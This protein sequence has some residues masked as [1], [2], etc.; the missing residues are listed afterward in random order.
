MTS[1]CDHMANKSTWRVDPARFARLGGLATLRSLG[2]ARVT[3]R[4]SPSPDHVEGGRTVGVNRVFACPR[5][6]SL[7]PRLA[8]I[9][10]CFRRPGVVRR[11]A[12][13]R[14]S[15]IRCGH[16]S[17]LEP[18]G[19]ASIVI[20]SNVYDHLLGTIAQKAVDGAASLTAHTVHIMRGDA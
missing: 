14:S 8:S 11:Y 16:R 2:R 13:Q 12:R 6:V 10:Q 20:T 3:P 18:R 7:G 9:P 1:R 4:L 15:A 5:S 17:R 19:H